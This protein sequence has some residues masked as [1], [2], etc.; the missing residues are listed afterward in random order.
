M[1]LPI[2]I[3]DGRGLTNEAHCKLLPKKIKVTLAIQ[4]TLNVLPAVLY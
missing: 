1:K 3:V 2:N 4:L